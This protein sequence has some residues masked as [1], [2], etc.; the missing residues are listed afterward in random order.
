LPFPHVESKSVDFLLLLLLYAVAPIW[1]CV[2]VVV[3]AGT[4]QEAGHIGLLLARP[5]R[6]M[7]AAYTGTVMLTAYT[8]TVMLAAYTG[9][10]MLAAYTGTVMLSLKRVEAEAFWVATACPVLTL[11][12]RTCPANM[13]KYAPTI[14]HVWDA[15]VTLV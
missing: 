15:V 1:M 8:G 3:C 5:L 9:T 11:V 13:C 6:G 2:F 10:V 4:L 14:R 7:L 12:L